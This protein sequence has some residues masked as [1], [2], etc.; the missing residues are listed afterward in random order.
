MSPEVSAAVGFV[1]AG[2]A[3]F[4]AAPLVIRAAAR[5]GFYDHPRGYHQHS[6]PTPLLGG[7]AVMAGF[8]LA[9]IVLN[10]DGRLLALIAC[11]VGLWLL[12]TLDDRTPV[13]PVWRLLAET[14]AALTLVLVG[15]GWRMYGGDG[16]HT[17]LTVV[18]VVGVI[19]AF[20]LMDN[21]DGACATVAAVSS[22]GIGALALIHGEAA[23]GALAFSLA[24][25]CVAFLRFNLASPARI[26]LGDGG[27]M[28][29]GLLVAGLAMAA[30]RRLGAGDA[31]LLAAALLVGVVILDTALVTVSRTR[32]GVTI[33]TGGRDHLTHRLLV[34]LRSPRTV[35]MTLAVVQ[36]V[37]CG[38][39]IAGE[40][41]GAAALAILALATTLLGLLAI[42]VLD[43]SR[44]RPPGVAAGATRA[45]SDRA[46]GLA[47]VDR[48]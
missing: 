16:S 8:V 29:I 20:N 30:T 38:I 27:S 33:V 18:W 13:A 23:V 47:Q 40:G 44:L 3:T 1:V 37:L 15:L 19:N 14:A 21:L 36:A 9:A 12:G 7:T 5:W 34:A 6:V 31:N 48:R 2:V 43:T 28:P 35:A 46:A 32:R 25:A 22:A 11:A 17:V 10:P 41:L 45:R 39:A 26:F 42:A 24:G 4:F